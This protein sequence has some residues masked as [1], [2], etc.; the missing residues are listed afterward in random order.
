MVAISWGLCMGGLSFPLHVPIRFVPIGLSVDGL[1]VCRHHL[2]LTNTGLPPI[3]SYELDYASTQSSSLVQHDA[4]AT[5]YWPAAA[6]LARLIPLIP[7]LQDLKVAELGCGTG[8]CSI[9]AAACGAHVIASDI[10]RVALKLVSAAAREQCL[11][12]LVIAK[13]DVL[14]EPLP[15][16]NVLILSDVFVT[17]PLT[18]AH[19][20][21]TQQALMSGA[22]VLVVDPGR[23][24]RS[25]Y[26]DSLAKLDVSHLGFRPDASVRAELS[27]LSE[28]GGWQRLPSSARLMLVD[29]DEGAPLHYEI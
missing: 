5:C 3:W 10:D 20:K 2:V 16:V 25:L 27:K 26:L 15:V 22:L 4:L 13:L 21:A 7:G 11:D 9:A 8:L 29:T 6:V 17:E 1:S 19:A 12:Q 28:P 23:P 14:H 24:T 18:V